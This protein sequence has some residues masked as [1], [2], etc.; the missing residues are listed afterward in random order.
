MTARA[1]RWLLAGSFL[2]F[3]AWSLIVPINEAPDEPAHW[4]YARYLH[5]HWQLPRY[6]P[7]FEEANSPPLAY[8]IF[9]PLA[10]DA[11]TPDMVL[12][13]QR[14]GDVVSL[15]EPRRFLNMGEDYGRYWPQRGARLVACAISAITVVL[16]WYAGAAAAG[17][18]V[19]LGAALLVAL[20]PMFAFRAGHVSNDA[21]VGCWTAAA[22]WGLVRLLREPFSWRGAGLTSAAVGL[23][24]MSKISA[25]ALLPPLALALLLAE[26]AASWRVRLSR[27]G[28]LAV[29]AAIVA[30][31]TIRNVA[32]YGDPFASQAMRHAVAHIIT[33]RSLFSSY[34]VD[35]FPRELA[36]SFVGNFGWGNLRL[37][38][39]A[40]AAYLALFVIGLGGATAAT[41]RR[42]LDW[43]LAGVL[44]VAGCAALAIV[45]RINL[46]FSQP[47]GRYLLPGLP[48]FAIL[49]AMGL[50]ALP[51]PFARLASPR[52]L[53][54]LLA[55]GNAGAL[56]LVVRPAYHPAPTRTLSTGER[57][58]LPSALYGLAVLDPGDSRFVVTDATPHWLTRVEAEA[59][60]F[61]A[62]E[63]TL[64]AVATPREQRA[65]IH[66]A[67]SGRGVADNPTLCSNWLADGLPHGIRIPVR[68]QPGWTNQVSHLWLNPFEAGVVPPGTEVRTANPRLVP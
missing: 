7:G 34:F 13:H 58:M 24:Y 42:Q 40:Y 3:A 57:V 39:V 11:S 60:A 10:S 53:G 26:P 19:G 15:A 35:P 51:A 18:Q 37:P 33:D 36:V 38:Y 45:V 43:R 41:L 56:L 61:S 59:A 27:L 64:T 16:V 4:Q 65:C 52:L 14:S 6:A 2:L 48:A 28:A 55:A 8:A 67:S 63:V 50:Q 47:Q 21:L 25:I 20:L 29:A 5:D 62:F 12:T 44:A 9:A 49:V 1:P 17:P 54:L 30:P 31:W 68:G 32:I 66:F 23:A 22:T 46:Q